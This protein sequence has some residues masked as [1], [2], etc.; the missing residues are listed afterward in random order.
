MSSLKR[1]LE[2]DETAIAALASEV[3]NLKKFKVGDRT[4]TMRE[5]P[6]ARPF[7]LHLPLH[8]SERE[9]SIYSNS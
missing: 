9:R 5:V 1:R 3:N 2:S 6:V 4:I 8:L 7:P